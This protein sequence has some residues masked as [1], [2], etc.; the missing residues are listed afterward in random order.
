MPTPGKDES[1]KDF[2]ARCIPMVLDEGTAEDGEQAAAICHSMFKQHQ[3]KAVDLGVDDELVCYGDAVKDLGDGKIGGYLIKFST[4]RDPDLVKDFFDAE[5]SMIEIPMENVPVFYAHGRDSKMGKRILGRGS[6]KKDEVGYWLEAQ[7][8]QRDEYEKAVLAMVKAGKLGY[9][10]GALPYLVDREPVGDGVNLIKTWVVGDASLT[11]TPAEPRISVVNSL[12]ALSI[13]E[14]AALPNEEI[15]DPISAQHI[16]E[17]HNMTDLPEIQAAID[18]A[19]EKRDAAAKA[20]AEKATALKAAEEAG[21]KKAVEELKS[22]HML[23]GAPAYVKQPGDDND[24]M[25]AF[26]SWLITGQENEGLIRPDP[27]WTKTAFSANGGVG[28]GGAFVPDPLYNTIIAKRD[29]SSWVR[30]APVQVFQTSSDHILVPVEGTKMTNFVLTNEFS[31]YNEN[32]AT[33]AQIDLILY[34]YTKQISS[35]EEFLNFQNTNFDSWLASGIARAVATTENTIYTVGS[36]GGEPQGIRTGATAGT[37]A[38][39]SLTAIAA[40]D[41]TY[42]VGLMPAGY[43]VASECGFLM[44][45]VTKWI[46]KSLASLPFPFMSEANTP[47]F[48]GYKCYVSDDLQLIGTGSAVG[49]IIF[50]NF[51]YYGIAEKP[52]IVIQRNPYLHMGTG[53]VDLFCNIFR[54]GAVLQAEAVYSSLNHA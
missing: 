9:S 40:L 39:S 3:K 27:S 51:N 42:L 15:A 41:L 29:L 26:K 18:A 22:K 46:T 37:T 6:I 16:K 17:K 34:K 28:V 45:N 11:P 8:Q 38:G 24:G 35:S 36:G 44:R 50:A 19:L 52:G 20:E 4:A 49:A 47:D 31:A 12:K 5:K 32:E 21:Y 10:S 54:G 43:N 30:Q 23:K 2:V 1:E 7:L 13:S 53:Q 25:L 14:V 33:T 48:V